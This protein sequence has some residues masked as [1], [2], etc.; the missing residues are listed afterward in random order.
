MRPITYYVHNLNKSFKFSKD[1]IS[2]DIGES[3]IFVILFHLYF[4]VT[5]PLRR[6]GRVA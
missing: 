1:M 5:L 3:R 2:G 4:Y 6:G